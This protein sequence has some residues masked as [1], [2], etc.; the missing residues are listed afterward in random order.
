M[1]CKNWYADPAGPAEDSC[2]NEKNTQILRTTSFAL[3]SKLL[4]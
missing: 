3:L 1:L 4:P 2:D